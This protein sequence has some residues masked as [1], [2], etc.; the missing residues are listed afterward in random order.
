MSKRSNRP[1]LRSV[2]A[3]TLMLVGVLATS[4]VAGAGPGLDSTT[5]V[6]NNQ[7]FTTS[8]ITLTGDAVAEPGK[9][10]RAVRVIIQDRAT[11]KWLQG[12]GA[13]ATHVFG[14]KA[15][16]D[17]KWSP[18]TSW[19]LTVEIPD[20]DY[21]F[22][23]IAVDN[24]GTREDAANQR[25]T[26]FSVEAAEPTEEYPELCSTNGDVAPCADGFVTIQFGRS[27]FGLGIDCVL[28]DQSYDLFDSADFLAAHGRFAQSTA[29]MGQMSTND[30][31][32]HCPFETQITAS[33]DDLESLRDD[34]DWTL[35]AD[36]QGIYD[37][38]GNLIEDRP[39][40]SDL[41]PSEQYRQSCGSLAVLQ[42]R[43]FD[44]AWGMFSFPGNVTDDQVQ[45]DIVS[46]CF[47]FS[48][49]YGPA[50]NVADIAEP[51]WVHTQSVNGGYC[52]DE[53]LPCHTAH[54]DEPWNA[55][56][57]KYVTPIQLYR[58]ATADGDA[59]SV[60]QF[61]RLV[62]GARLAEDHAGEEY[63][64]NQYWDC[65]D[66]D[67]RAH[68]TSQGELYCATDFEA[69][70]EMLPDSYYS[71]DAATMAGVIGRGN[72]NL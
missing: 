54:L 67:P 17:P 38:D 6:V 37:E 47:S 35:T 33:W 31:E 14:F 57:R 26:K 30:A 51:W 62:E 39:R 70:V 4:S 56:N 16:L 61:Y 10:I 12:S 19:S 72:P 60:I 28:S 18:S 65:T 3:A 42:S 11:K 25:W 69:F 58:R 43:G 71:V 68:W 5:N 22:H 23:S 7:V 36:S 50:M 15:E 52:H 27:Q 13:F 21:G 46:E 24:D 34:Y 48:R 9:K 44:R 66:P 1:T 32:R 40:M 8:T 55:G 29:A 20:G 59:W 64:D 53:S 45:E 41:D 49:K 2:V 63:P